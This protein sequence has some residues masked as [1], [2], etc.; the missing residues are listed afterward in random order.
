MKFEEKI[1][2]LM[3]EV[4]SK[5]DVDFVKYL[6]SKNDFD[7][8]NVPEIFRKQVLTIAKKKV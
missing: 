7:I 6:F 8:K 3:I 2:E 4:A 1:D 5:K